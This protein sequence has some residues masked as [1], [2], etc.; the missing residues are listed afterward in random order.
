M[1]GFGESEREYQDS[2]GEM[3][4]EKEKHG[5]FSSETETTTVDPYTGES[6][7]VEEKTNIFGFTSTNVVE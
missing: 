2:N 4:E 5:W 1:F 3:V 7:T 6:R